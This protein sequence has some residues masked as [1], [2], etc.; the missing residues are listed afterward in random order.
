MSLTLTLTL[1]AVPRFVSAHTRASKRKRLIPIE[2]VTRPSPYLSLRRALLSAPCNFH[3]ITPSWGPDW[4]VSDWIIG[5][6][7][8]RMHQVDNV[9]LPCVLFSCLALREL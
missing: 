2:R 4:T 9:I 6:T 7:D 3:L 8:E 5:L 1:C